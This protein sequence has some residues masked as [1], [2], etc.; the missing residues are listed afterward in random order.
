MRKSFKLEFCTS[1]RM[2][3]CKTKNYKYG[4]NKVKVVSLTLSSALDI[5]HLSRYYGKSQNK[6]KILLTINN[7][8]NKIAD[9]WKKWLIK[10]WKGLQNFLSYVL[11]HPSYWDTS[12]SIIFII[13][14]PSFKKTKQFHYLCFGFCNSSL[15]RLFVRWPGYVI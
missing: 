12:A 8:G 3:F 11:A 5:I 14:W 15:L 6:L 13:Y 7:K 1:T 2:L 4:K 9:L 10:L